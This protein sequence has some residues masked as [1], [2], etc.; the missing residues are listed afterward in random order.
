MGKK[1]VNTT[2]NNINI[3]QRRS[4]MRQIKWILDPGHGGVAFGHYV[5]KGKRSPHVPP[6]IYEGEFNREVALDTHFKWTLDIPP[7]CSPM[8][9]TMIGTGPINI[10]LKARVDFVNGL[11]F[12]A[13]DMALISIHA[14]AEGGLKRGEWGKASGS[15]L[16]ISKRAS[17]GSYRLEDRLSL[18]MIDAMKAGKIP[19]AM[20]PTRLV[21]HTITTRVKCPAILVE[22]GFMTNEADAT[23]LATEGASAWADVIFRAMLAYQEGLE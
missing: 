3:P 6:G 23:W 22:C 12:P 10:P 18:A 16:F 5:T 7:G 15:R 14:N 4:P 8:D 1:A 2:N 21:N 9:C 19:Y 13:R 11:P 17:N 20:R